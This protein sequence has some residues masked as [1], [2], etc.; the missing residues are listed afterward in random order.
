MTLE[1]GL[2][3][4]YGESM[5]I[6]KR[7]AIIVGSV[8][9]CLILIVYLLINTFFLNSYQQAEEKELTADAGRLKAV[10]SYKI[11]TLAA[12]GRDWSV[13]DETFN[14]LSGRNPGYVA[15]NITDATFANLN[16][17]FLVFIDKEGH[18]VYEKGYNPAEK[19]EE[20]VPE[21]IHR[22]I[23]QNRA[24]LLDPAR[25]VAGLVNFDGNPALAAFH[26]VQRSNEKGPSAGTLLIG[27]YLN[28]AEL[29]NLT[30]VTQMKL[31]VQPYYFPPTGFQ[32]I[33]SV[34][35]ES[36]LF[37]RDG[38][39][40]LT[41]LLP[42]RDI[43]GNQSLAFSVQIPRTFYRQ[44]IVAKILLIAAISV[45]GLIFGVLIIFLIEK[46]I[47]S[48]LYRL[49]TALDE[50]GR[51]HNL[52]A[53][54]PVEGNDE[55]TRLGQKIN[56]M[57]QALKKSNLELRENEERFQRIFDQSPL[58]IVL[59]DA[60]GY[61]VDANKAFLD[62]FGISQREA[63][64]RISLIGDPNISPEIVKKILTNQAVHFEV[65]Y[66]FDL[67]LKRRHYSTSK[68]GKSSFDWT[69]TPLKVTALTFSGFL[70]QIQNVTQRKET[71]IQLK[72]LSLYDT[73]T[74]LFN[75]G[76]FEKEIR[77]LQ[78]GEDN[79]I[80]VI[81]ADVDGLK[82]VNDTFG[83]DAGDSL[84]MA[85][86][87]VI[88]DSFRQGDIIARIGGDEFAVLLPGNDFPAAERAGERIREAVSRYN[89]IHRSPF[90]LSV[91]VGV[92]S[93]D[94]TKIGIDELIKEADNN[95]YREKLHHNQSTRS[96]IVQTLMKAL[97]ARDMDTEWHGER[98]QDFVEKLG[99][100]AGV[101]DHGIPDLRLF[102]QFHDIGKVGVADIILF[103]PSRLTPDEAL[104]MQRHCEIGYRIAQASQDLSP[105][106]NL[107]LLHHEW[108]NGTGYPLRLKGEDIPLGCRI[109]AI[110]DAY[111]AMT[112]NRPYRKAL[113]TAQALAELRKGAG[114]QFDPHLVVIFVKIVEQMSKE[115][116]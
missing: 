111:D 23:D 15:D 108:W 9:I 76:Y 94:I 8:T 19:K 107:I 29:N 97:K 109:L 96:E 105:I 12:T 67:I 26:P 18:V 27:R 92:T 69:I 62:M 80:G 99:R 24:I 7:T 65:D 72:Y 57:L 91:S 93:G 79:I 20:P 115:T 85:A 45:F 2:L 21:S 1:K 98:L 11:E 28:A 17:N 6:L 10:L 116:A 68:R 82:L 22:Y 30:D 3:L 39:N 52:S 63:V 73:L 13:W 112:N 51:R 113:S 71:E 37:R 77:N 36:V 14:F 4:M 34:A 89:I 104:E 83:H 56:E 50:I 101:P 59:F 31:A 49:G 70:C 40:F 114:V 43:A 87:Q 47:L 61:A 95:M 48:R 44:G 46:Y 5:T 75:R 90:P 102:A 55:L 38:G 60:E 58:G 88:K 42:F 106:A 78:H 103:K 100:A 84:L 25:G 32:E 66:D 64:N 41:A 110:A 16:V 35:G 54:V 86:S 33:I 53:R 81:M 74:G